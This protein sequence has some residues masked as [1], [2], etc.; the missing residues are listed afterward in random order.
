MRCVVQ[1]V[2]SAS[3]EVE[4]TR[5]AEIGPG[6]LVLVGATHSDTEDDARYI[7]QKV[8]NLR[9]FADDDG[10]MNRSALDLGAELLIVSQFTLLGDVRKGRR[11][12]FVDA[13]LPDVAAPLVARVVAHTRD[14]GLNVQTGLFGAEMAVA[15]VNDGPVTIWID[16]TESPS[17]IA[18]HVPC[19]ATPIV[20]SGLEVRPNPYEIIATIQQ[21][22]SRNYGMAYV[23]AK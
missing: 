19:A 10:K 9:I 5:I 14:L 16:T 3:V 21:V 17:M 20:T 1:R 8:A 15:L 2:R 6:L 13:A 11:P 7:A 12:S 18:E 22:R 23:C 4:G